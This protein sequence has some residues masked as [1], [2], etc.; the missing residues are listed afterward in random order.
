MTSKSPS[1]TPQAM[2]P[3]PLLPLSAPTR[4]ALCAELGLS[5]A[6]APFAVNLG[7]QITLVLRTPSRKTE[8]VIYYLFM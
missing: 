3:P 5:H 4:G 6:Y 2:F 7:V 8:H 1:Q